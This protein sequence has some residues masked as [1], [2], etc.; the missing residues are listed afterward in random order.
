M[1][2]LMGFGKDL[3][4]GAATLG[5]EFR[6]SLNRGTIER[7]FSAIVGSLFDLVMGRGGDGIPYSSAETAHQQSHTAGNQVF[8]IHGQVQ[9]HEDA[10]R[11][12]EEATIAAARETEA[13]YHAKRESDE[14]FHTMRKAD[15]EDFAQKQT[16]FNRA[17][18]QS[19]DDGIRL[20]Q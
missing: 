19:Q 8:H 20:S 3:M 2:R 15:E 5:Q 6:E 4:H 7:E 18:E 17:W 11:S 16:A 9:M 14:Q 1:S 13:W 12:T 10:A